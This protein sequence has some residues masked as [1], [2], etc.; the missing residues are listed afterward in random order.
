MWYVGKT[1]KRNGKEGKRINATSAP[2]MSFVGR[3]IREEKGWTRDKKGE[4]REI[5]KELLT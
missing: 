3:Q 5:E 2:D 1:N 4:R